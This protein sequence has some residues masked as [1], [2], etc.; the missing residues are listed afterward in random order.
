M[1]LDEDLKYTMNVPFGTIHAWLTTSH[2]LT[3]F[4]LNG[5]VTVWLCP[6]PRNVRANPRSTFGGSP[7]SAGKP[8]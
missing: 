1:A 3:S 8:R 6:R 5:I 2:T 7:Y 4:N